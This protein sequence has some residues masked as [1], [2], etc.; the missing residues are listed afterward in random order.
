MAI[1]VKHEGNVTSRVVASAIGG[2]G[3]RDAEDSK[4][5][6]Q[7]AAQENIAANRQLQGAH[8]SPSAPYSP[9]AQLGHASMQQASPVRQSTLDYARQAVR[10]ER[11]NDLAMT[12]D[13]NLAKLREGAAIAEDERRAQMWKEEFSTKQR[14]EI[15]DLNNM[16]EE[17]LAS[18][19]YSDAEKKVL[20]DQLDARKWGI[21]PT[22]R[23]KTP[24]EIE[25][26]NFDP[27]RDFAKN[28]Y[29][30]PQGNVWTRDPRGGWRIGQAV[31]PPA[32]APDPVAEEYKATVEANRSARASLVKSLM[33]EMVEGAPGEP[34][35]PRYTL[36]EAA[37]KARELAD[38][39]YPLPQYRTS[40][41]KARAE[42]AVRR[43]QEG[44]MNL[45]A[46]ARS[47]LPPA[48]AQPTPAVGPLAAPKDGKL[49]P[50]PSLLP[51]EEQPVPQTEQA[52][53]TPEEKRKRQEE[54]VKTAQKW[55]V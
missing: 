43:V 2:K 38:A 25:A 31:K 19:R 11:L 4:A 51:P 23:L 46:P 13:E 5:L 1:K 9:Q 45:S 8:A 24:E 49:Q 40:E 34:K 16:R 37:A 12:R 55:I 3:R 17:I 7:K 42:E 29:T 33:S 26:D 47:V 53:A 54:A 44:F 52:P 50:P 30:D 39:L 15:D 48:S 22:S 18:G 10:D 21:Q 14:A 28:S 20:L 6:A 36:E 35:K 27:A 32:S 41:E